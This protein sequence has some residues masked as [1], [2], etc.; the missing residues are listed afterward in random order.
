MLKYIYRIII[1]LAVFA[2]ALFYFS[3]NIREVVSDKNS[4]TQMENVTFPLVTIKTGDNTINQLH[5]Y[6]SSLNANTIR[7]GITP[8]SIDQS[9]II[10]INEEDFKIK[11]LNYELREKVG[12]GLVEQGSISVF[13]HVDKEKAA[14][15]KLNTKLAADKEYAVKI[16]LISSKSDRIYY[17]LTV[18]VIDQ[19]FLS[20]KLQFVMDF[21]NAL[22]AKN[23]AKEL[24]KYLE[25]DPAADNTSLSYVNIHSSFDLISWGNLKPVYLTEAIPTVKEIYAD[26]ALIELDYYISADI[27]RTKEYFRVKEAYRVRY[28]PQRM[29]LLNY[30]RNMEAFFDINLA[31]ISKNELKLGITSDNKVPYITTEDKKKLAFVRN[32][33][34]WFYNLEEN[35][36][37][38]VFS[39][40]QE[41]PDY[42]RD[43]YDQ[44][45]IRIMNL[46]AEGNLY[47][48]VYGY[49][50]RGE[51]EGRVG[52]ILYQYIPSENRIEELVYIPVEEPYQI[53][54]E[55]LDDFAYVNSRDVFF[56]HM[57]NNIYS[58]NLITKKVKTVAKDVHKDRIVVLK[59]L[60]HLVWQDNSD[61][62][63]SKNINIMNMETQE[64]NTINAKSGYN[65]ILMGSVD[66]NVIYG[67]VKEK[68][69]ITDR[70]GKVIY[71]L[72]SLEIADVNKK[73]LKKY[74][75]KGYYISDVNV[76]DNVIELSR[77]KKK[78][79]DFVPASK[80]YIMNE[81]REEEKPVSAT[82]RV[83]P[84]ALTEWYLSLPKGF[85][86]NALP[87]VTKTVSTVISEDTTV[88]LP[89]EEQKPTYYYP[90]VAGGIRG[91]YEDACDAIKIADE[92]TGSVLDNDQHMVWERGMK[93]ATSVISYFSN[94]S[95]VTT[96]GNTPETCIDLMLKYQGINVNRSKL[97]TEGSSAFEI[98]QKYSK[99]TPVNLTGIT[100][101]EAF[102]YIAAGRPVIA[103]T[104]HKNA[105]LIYGY[106]SFNIMVIDPV[107][108]TKKKMGIGD[109]TKLF[110]KAG[111][112][113]LSYLE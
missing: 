89:I 28:T 7:D 91:S 61:P 31:S 112:V 82:K 56:F 29:Y 86:M 10:L 102:Y 24:S 60:N 43:L 71:P 67:F 65:V 15:I 51:Y 36:I 110:E 37:T 77:V 12:N 48:M 8:L 6:S 26:T 4:T 97:K 79:G 104:G 59:D 21:H 55:K 16:S 83:T 50:N 1:L 70:D 101:D 40:R 85:T 98:L 27:S 66:S 35:K 63:K 41:K 103:F 73:I 105:V 87:K 23:T 53:L 109:S 75:K 111:N 46:D 106:D 45:D 49:M 11:K 20:E 78:N 18:K 64:L 57:D 69:I 76:K 108:K 13:D 33:E 3:Q 62:K 72:N 38:N 94:L 84:K 100:L 99:Y 34:L 80:D 90:Y 54:K 5:G 17:Y 32:N 58:Y 44:H 68:N 81:I 52:I 14:K 19:A 30:E 92:N 88:R 107:T 9:F 113:F 96:A 95:G 74:K 25:P 2:A 22:K 93:P 42:L 47:F 39:F